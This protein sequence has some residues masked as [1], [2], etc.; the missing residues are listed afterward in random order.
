M[1]KKNLSNI[2]R[3]CK[4]FNRFSRD[5]KGGKVISLNSELC[6]GIPTHCTKMI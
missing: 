3:K 5:K 1:S 6:L 4:R 2:G